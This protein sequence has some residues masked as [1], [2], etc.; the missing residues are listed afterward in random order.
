MIGSVVA[1]IVIL[2]LVVILYN[3]LLHP[4]SRGLFSFFVPDATLPRPSLD[5]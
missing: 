2:G 3:H 1:V 4:C 5:S